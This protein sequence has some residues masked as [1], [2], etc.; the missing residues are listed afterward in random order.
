MLHRPQEQ[1]VYRLL[2][3]WKEDPEEAPATINIKLDD[4]T[5]HNPAPNAKLAKKEYNLFI[6]TATCYDAAKISNIQN[7]IQQMETITQNGDQKAE[8]SYKLLKTL[9][10]KIKININRP[11]N[12]SDD[13]QLM[14]IQF[15]TG[16]VNEA[17]VQKDAC[18]G[19]TKGYP[20]LQISYYLGWDISG[21]IVFNNQGTRRF[22]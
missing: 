22:Q 20:K 15:D 3:G 16:T 21:A 4:F 1:S 6:T 14:D 18:K 2:G 7:F 9:Q 13:I 19:L 11:D 10:F 5:I 12:E 17:D 8:I